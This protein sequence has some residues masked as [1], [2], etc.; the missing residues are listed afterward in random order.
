MNIGK[1]SAGVFLMIFV[2][3]IGVGL[4]LIGFGNGVISQVSDSGG[5]I[6]YAVGY[7]VIGGG[8]LVIAGSVAW[9]AVS[10]IIAIIAMLAYKA[11]TKFGNRIK[12]DT[13]AEQKTVDPNLKADSRLPKPLSDD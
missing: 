10:L 9:A 5:G 1:V 6:E 11:R 12:A 13:A 2:C 8:Y 3:G 4:A 7:M